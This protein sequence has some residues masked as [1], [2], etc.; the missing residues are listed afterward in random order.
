ML[1]GVSM[2]NLADIGLTITIIFL[3]MKQL[4]IYHICFVDGIFEMY[5][6]YS[7]FLRWYF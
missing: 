7:M 1:V 6:V 3:L 2:N 5:Q 4:V